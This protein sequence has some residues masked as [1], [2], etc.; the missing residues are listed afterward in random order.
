[1]ARSSVMGVAEHSSA[2]LFRA[3]APSSAWLDSCDMLVARQFHSTPELKKDT[4]NILFS[5]TINKFNVPYAKSQ[6]APQV[7]PQVATQVAPQVASQV[8]VARARSFS[9]AQGTAKKLVLGGGN[10]SD[11]KALFQVAHA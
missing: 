5:Y 11:G 10:G 1:V 2:Q 4:K 7:A 3:S 6:I 9:L 8:K